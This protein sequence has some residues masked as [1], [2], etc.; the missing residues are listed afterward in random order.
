M[1]SVA[2]SSDGI[3]HFRS[4][5]LQTSYDLL[6]S[7]PEM[8]RVLLSL[9]INKLGDVD[10]KV[11]GKAN[12]LLTQLVTQHPNMK[13]GKHRQPNQSCCGGCC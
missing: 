2:A 12:Y 10:K 5:V 1:T 8:E 3:S 4:F 11:G 6:V 7:K 9:I 13:L